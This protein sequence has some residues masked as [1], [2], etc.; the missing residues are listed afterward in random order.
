[1]KK[2]YLDHAATTYVKDEVFEVMKPYFSEV[3]GNA[4]SLH[5]FGRD[6]AAAVDTAREKIAK[7]IG[8]KPNE[9]YFTSGG[10]ESDN[11]AI[12]GIAKRQGKGHIITSDIEHPAV[13]ATCEEL[14]KQGF[15]VSYI[16]VDK[17]GTILLEELEK[18]IRPDT[19]LIS[20]MSANNE[21]GTIQP[22]DEIGKIAKAHKIPFHTD[23]VQAVGAI[24]FNVAE[25]NIDMLSMSAHKFYG[26][27]GIGVLFIRNGLGIGKFLTGG[28]QERSMRAG[29]TMTPQIVGMGRAIEIAYEN[30]DKENQ[31]LS[32]MRDYLIN[33]ILTEIPGTNLNGHKTNRLPNN[34][35]IS[36]EF[37]EGESI[38]I[39]LDME[40]IA[41]STGSACSSGS[42][43][44]SRVLGAMGLPI[45]LAHGSIRMTLG[46]RNTIEDIDYVVEKLK[47]AIERL[48]KMSPLFNEAK[49]VYTNV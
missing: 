4:S 45:E 13:I 6:A 42:L 41:V 8:A 48:R 1:M 10:S 14:K 2:V 47:A 18:A 9:I 25:Q 12:R 17:D 46:E 39:L 7:A 31:R 33:R 26:P 37:I 11:W 44:S 20:V 49:G 27:K 5:G 30:L 43:K 3:F 15:E 28:E 16:G 40:G 38:L 22:I 21:V 19:I 23:A 24:R 29:T 36:Y 35:N 34:L 32:S